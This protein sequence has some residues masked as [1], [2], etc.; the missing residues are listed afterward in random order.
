LIILIFATNR[1]YAGYSGVNIRLENEWIAP[2]RQSAAFKGRTFF[3]TDTPFGR[4]FGVG[5]IVMLFPI[6]C[7]YLWDHLK[8]I[9]AC[10]REQTRQIRAGY[11]LGGPSL[12]H[13]RRQ[14][15]S[16]RNFRDDENL[17]LCPIRLTLTKL[18]RWKQVV[19]PRKL[20]KL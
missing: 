9:F 17:L 11:W 8:R 3:N 16:M 19:V 10:T 13:I 4:A 5:F 1:F 14:S 7:I 20:S 2:W 18:P 12:A 15:S 6:G